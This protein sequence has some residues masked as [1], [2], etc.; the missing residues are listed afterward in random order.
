MCL[1]VCFRGGGAMA[2]REVASRNFLGAGAARF[3]SG[4]A[5]LG[6]LKQPNIGHKLAVIVR[7]PVIF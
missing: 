4:A 6:F 3:W 7:K 2:R 1:C 5:P